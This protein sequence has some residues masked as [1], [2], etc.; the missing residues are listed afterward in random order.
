MFAHYRRKEFLTLKLSA[1]ELFLGYNFLK[2]LCEEYPSPDLQRMLIEMEN[3]IFGNDN[4]H[5]CRA[6][7]MPLDTSKDAFTHRT[8]AN[9]D[10]HWFHQK[11]PVKPDAERDFK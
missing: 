6:C 5:T 10:S 2:K 1:V 8:E 9:G 4:I 3:D 11:C 7:F